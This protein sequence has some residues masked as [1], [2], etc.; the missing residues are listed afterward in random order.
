M[1]PKDKYRNDWIYHQLTDS[2]KRLMDAGEMSP[3]DVIESARLACDMH[4]NDAPFPLPIGKTLQT[5][6]EMQ[7]KFETVDIHKIL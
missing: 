4:F 2:L 6:K 3:T 7:K 5:H 1:T